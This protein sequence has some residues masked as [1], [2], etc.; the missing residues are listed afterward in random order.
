MVA[1][2]FILASSYH[3][4]LLFSSLSEYMCTWEVMFF[5]SLFRRLKCVAN[6]RSVAINPTNYQW[7]PFYWVCAVSSL[8]MQLSLYSIFFHFN[9]FS[10]DSIRY[11]I[12]FDSIRLIRIYFSAY[13]LV[14]LLYYPVFCLGK[15]DANVIEPFS[16]SVHTICYNVAYNIII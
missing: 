6:V 11:D 9:R 1:H 2:H 3:R 5:L 7:M 14:R 13:T 12:L 16:E 15:N 10:F 8:L 4:S